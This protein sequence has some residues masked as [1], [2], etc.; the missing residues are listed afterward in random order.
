MVMAG[1]VIGAGTCL[2]LVPGWAGGWVGGR[3]GGLVGAAETENL[4][5][6]P[7]LLGNL[8]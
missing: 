2:R 5:G 7:V 4:L 3:V 8:N 1:Y 6:N